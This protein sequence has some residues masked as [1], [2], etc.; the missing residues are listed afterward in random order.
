MSKYKIGNTTL[1]FEPQFSGTAFLE[2]TAGRWTSDDVDFNKAAEC[3]SNGYAGIIIDEDG[4]ACLCDR[5]QF[6]SATKRL[7]QCVVRKKY[8]P[9]K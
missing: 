2:I 1:E 7:Q 8:F 4:Q 9:F 3:L 6:P 5:R